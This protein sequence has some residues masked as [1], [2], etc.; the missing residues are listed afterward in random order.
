MSTLEVPN[1]KL[2]S[3]S[4][5]AKDGLAHARKL[6][7]K[8]IPGSVNLSE[9]TVVGMASTISVDRD[10]EIILPSSME[11][12]LVR[13]LASNAPFLAQHT[14]R[15][16]SARPAQIGWV[17]EGKVS[18]YEVPCLFRYGATDAAEDW[19]KLASDPKGKGHAFSI[20]FRPLRWV[21]GNVADLVAQFP[22][23]ADAVKAEGLAKDAQ[24]T[25]YTEIELYEI[26]ACGVPSNRDAVQLDGDGAAEGLPDVAELKS[27]MDDLKS[28][29]VQLQS[30]LIDRFDELQSMLASD[31]INPRGHRGCTAPPV[32]GGGEIGGASESREEQSVSQIAAGHLAQ[33]L[34]RMRH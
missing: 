18:G 29:I 25:V 2:Q 6:L 27:Q 16:D 20:G 22:E 8:S 31:D 17:V 30:M 10:G 4:Y 28:E 32:G 15:T 9:R 23:I 7:G 26:S 3:G 21:R 13:F 24:L 1:S 12:D 19:W 5:D 11:T 14:H 34:G 33:T